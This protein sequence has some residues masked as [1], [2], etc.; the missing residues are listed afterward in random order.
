MPM[1]VGQF[2][3]R[4]SAHGGPMP[5]KFQYS[6]HQIC[7]CIMHRRLLYLVP[8]IRNQNKRTEGPVTMNRIDQS[9]DNFFHHV[10]GPR[11]INRNSFHLSLNRLVRC[12]SRWK[13]FTTVA[14]SLDLWCLFLVFSV[15]LF[16]TFYFWED[17]FCSTYNCHYPLRI[18]YVLG[19]LWPFTKLIQPSRRI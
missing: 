18:F 8:I 3:R 19:H 13:M 14:S 11:P 17:K 1:V 9:L 10:V 6:T 16:C 7:Q 15:L 4:T 5:E 12:S 2:L